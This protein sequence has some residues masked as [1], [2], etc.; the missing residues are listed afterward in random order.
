MEV[1]KDPVK[2]DLW[3]EYDRHHGAIVQY[4]DPGELEVGEEG[5]EERMELQ[6]VE[7]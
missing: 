5:A 4:C 7:I 6:I 2:K 3:P 1:K